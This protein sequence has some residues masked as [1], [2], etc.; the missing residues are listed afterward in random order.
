MQPSD[1]E[2]AYTT[3]GSGFYQVSARLSNIDFYQEPNI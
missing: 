1:I 3:P 2:A